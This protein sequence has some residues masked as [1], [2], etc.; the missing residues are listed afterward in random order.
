MANVAASSVVSYQ[1]GSPTPG[2]NIA[3]SALG[4][5]VGNTSSGVWDTGA[6]TPFNSAWGPEHIVVVEPGGSLVLKFAQPLSIGNTTKLG[7]YSNNSLMQDP[8]TGKSTSDYAL[9][10][11]PNRAYL[12]I[13]ADGESWLTRGDGGWSAQGALV[14]FENPG[15]AYTDNSVQ[16]IIERWGYYYKASL[17]TQQSDYYKPFAGTLSDFGDKTYEQMLALLDGS[18]GG[19][20][21]DLSG[22]GLDSVQYVRFVVPEGA[23]GYHMVVDSVVVT[24]EPATL[25]VLVVAGLAL[26]QRRRRSC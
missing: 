10:N 23:S 24:P 22:S 2:Q 4:L 5:P 3:N 6:L 16:K 1:P 21:F 7:I 15:N 9:L 25:G 17:G 12:S 18:A 13:S 26:T 14:S 20:W 19:N 8:D 11:T